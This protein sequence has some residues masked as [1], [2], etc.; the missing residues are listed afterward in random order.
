M[1]I[2]NKNHIFKKIVIPLISVAD[3]LKSVIFIFAEEVHGMGIRIRLYGVERMRREQRIG[4]S[5]I[6]FASLNLEMTSTHW[7]ILEPRSNLSVCI[8]DTDH[9]AR[10]LKQY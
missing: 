5:I 6:G 10:T 7:I 3:I 4:E 8:L 2:L 9:S 1:F